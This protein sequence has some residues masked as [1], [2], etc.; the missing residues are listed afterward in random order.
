M[1]FYLYFTIIL[2]AITAISSGRE[3]RAHPTFKP[4]PMS[5]TLNAFLFVRYQLHRGEPV[6]VN[7]WL[8]LLAHVNG[9]VCAILFFVR[10]LP[11]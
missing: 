8:F 10:A 1:T 9:L 2:F 7:L 6:S 11:N 3:M 5:G 4:V